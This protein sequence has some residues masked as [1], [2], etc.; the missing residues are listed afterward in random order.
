MKNLEKL[1]K[2]IYDE[3]LADKEPVTMEEATEMAKAEIGADS[4]KNYVDTEKTKNRATKGKPREVKVSDEKK[5][6]FES[7]FTNLDR[8]EGVEPAGIHILKDNKLIEVRI[9]EKVFKIDIIEQR[10][11]KK[12]P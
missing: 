2:Q 3:C 8:C 1:A 7:I 10:P 6:L 4:I 12:T 5:M 11:P 9:G